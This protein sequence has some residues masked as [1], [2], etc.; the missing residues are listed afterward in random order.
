MSD[1][2]KPASFVEN[3]NTVANATTLASGDIL[4]DAKRASNEARLAAKLAKESAIASEEAEN[5]SEEWAEKAFNSEVENNKFSAFHWA[6]KARL[7][8]GD[9]L[10][11][12]QLTSPLYTWSS[13]KVMNELLTKSNVG[14]NHDNLYEKKFNKSSAFN[15]P[16]GGN[17]VV[18]LVARSDHD[19]NGIYEP[20]IN[21]GAPKGTAFNKN[22]GTSSGTVSEGDHLHNQYMQ[23]SVYTVNSLINP[24]KIPW[25]TDTAAPLADEV[26]RGTHTHPANKIPYDSSIDKVITASTVQ[27]AMGQLDSFI[28]VIT[29]AEKTHL[30]AGISQVHEIPVVGA[31]TPV[32]LDNPLAVL[33]SGNASITNGADIVVEYPIAETPKKKIEGTVAVSITLTSAMTQ[34]IA[35]SIAVDGNIVGEHSSGTS[36]TLTLTKHLTNLDEHGFTISFWVTNR[37][38]TANIFIDSMDVMWVGAPEGAVVASGTTVDHSDLTGTGAPNGVHTTSDILDLDTVLASKAD[39]VSSSTADNLVSLDATGNIADSGIPMSTI[40]N[41]VNKVSPAVLDNIIVMTSDGNAKDAGV[42]VS[43]LAA[44][45]GN[46]AQTFDVANG[47]GTQAVNKDQ[48]DNSISGFATQVDL[49]AHLA[50]TDN[51][52]GLTPAKINAAEAVHTHAM[53]DVSGLTDA[54]AAKYAIVPTAV[55]DNLMAFETGGL[56]KDSGVAV[57]DI[58]QPD[59]YATD[60]VGG[61]IKIKVI[62]SDCYITTDGSTPG[63]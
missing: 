9:P 1:T 55:T 63:P 41:L 13:E 45:G 6:E 11:N 42:K 21:N 47:S 29:I 43:D 44:V 23:S 40:G 57:G 27:G 5:K 59:S 8:I 48:L 61:T 25:V 32:K 36:R 60:L 46:S 52:H 22:F 18:N 30:T 14:H 24:A 37:T 2:K 51:P 58:V 10:L 53:T 17:G 62:G 20:A 28:G 38:D 7:A 33:A 39:R 56:V 31:N 35:L 49:D 34:D 3:I 12:D 54:L 26:N 16:F 19:H 4:E 15:L 50:D